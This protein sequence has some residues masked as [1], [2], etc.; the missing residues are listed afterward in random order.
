MQEFVNKLHKLLL[1][2]SLLFVFVV[3]MYVISQHPLVAFRPTLDWFNTGIRDQYG[4]K[5]MFLD[6]PIVVQQAVLLIVFLI[7][8]C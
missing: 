2:I 5:L 1:I 4:E 6:I 8:V 7:A 3:D